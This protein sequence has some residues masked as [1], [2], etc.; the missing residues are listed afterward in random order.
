[1]EIDAHFS[2]IVKQNFT[3]SINCLASSLHLS[4]RS[5][6]ESTVV[7]TAL[8]HWLAL[9]S[10]EFLAGRCRCTLFEALGLVTRLGARDVKV[11]L[12]LDLGVLW[13]GEIFSAADV[14]G[15]W[16]G[17]SSSSAAVFP[18]SGAWVL[19]G[20]T[21][22]W[23]LPG[24]APWARPRSSSPSSG[25][26]STTTATKVAATIAGSWSATD[27]GLTAGVARAR[28]SRA[29]ALA[30]RAAWVIWA[31]MVAALAWFSAAAAMMAARF[32]FLISFIKATATSSK[33]VI[34]NDKFN[35]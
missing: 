8:L 24:V 26:R 14:L 27:R 17:K 34:R 10:L 11:K 16:L 21:A 6:S 15:A 28:E 29:G 18:G 35:T 2:R 12:C 20:W 3:F 33:A 25:V 7:T 9:A 23:V 19:L 5:S 22:S 13:P 4:L 32:A 1:M 30:F 31:V